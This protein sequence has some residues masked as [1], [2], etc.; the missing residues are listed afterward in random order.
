MLTR[1]CKSVGKRDSKRPCPAERRSAAASALVLAL[2]MSAPGCYL[3]DPSLDEGAIDEMSQE[4]SSSSHGGGFVIVS[5]DDADDGGHCQGTRCGGIY[6]KF[7]AQAVANSETGGTT[8]AIL[9]IGVNGSDARFSLDG[10]NQPANGGPGKPITYLTNATDIQNVDFS[11]FA[12]IYI[13]S[14]ERQT[15]GGITG[16]QITAL[17]SRQADITDFVNNQGGA[18][19][20]LTQANAPGGWGFLPVTLTTL[21]SDF[22]RAE[23]TPTLIDMA[24]GVT[25]GNLE[26]CCYHNVFTGPSGF[27]GLDVLAF[28][29]DTN[30]PSGFGLPVILGGG[31]LS[32]EICNDQRDNDGDGLIDKADPDCFICG[33][34]ILD[35]DEQCDDGNLVG[36]DGCNGVCQLENP[37]G[38]GAINPGE[39]CDDGNRNNGDGCDSSCQLENRAPDAVCED[40][41]ECNDP[42]VCVAAITLGA[43]STDPDGD[44]LSV[45]QSPAGPYAVGDH[46]VSVTVSDGS[47]QDSCSS[48]VEV[49]DCEPP[50]LTC[51]QNFQLQCTGNGSAQVTPPAATVADN[52]SA[53]V[54]APAPGSMPLGTS[55]LTYT[56]S[57]P[58]GNGASCVTAVTVV[59]TI[60]PDLSCPSNS[61]AECTG[62]GQ[63]V[64][65]PGLA[66]TSDICTDAT[67]NVPGTSS[68]PLGT[69]TVQY[70]ARDQSGNRASCTTNV[71]VQDTR[72][73]SI[74]CPAP[75]TAE[76]TGNRQ[77]VVDPGDAQATDVCTAVTVSDPGATSYPL[78]TSPVDYVAVDGSGNQSSCRTSITVQDTTPP[79]LSCSAPSVA[80]C[81]GNGQAVVDP[82]LA[83]ASDI[84]TDATVNVPGAASYPLGST[85]VTYTAMDGVGHQSSCTTSV[86]VADTIAPVISCPAPLVIE[87]TG[88][89]SAPVTPGQATASDSCTS[90]AITGPAPGTFPVGT[91]V[92]TYTATDLSGNQSSCQSTIEVR[93]TT[94]PVVSVTA[95]DPMWPPNHKYRNFDLADCGIVVEDE[96]GGVLPPS[97]SAPTITCVTSDEPENTRGDGNTADDIRIIDGDTVALRAERDGRSDGRVY[98][99]HFQVVDAAGNMATGVCPIGVPHDQRG[100]SAVDSGAAYSVCR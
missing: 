62:N 8:K 23:P 14:Y 79:A 63:A 90:A 100:T 72:D 41:S 75:S 27:S 34:N 4:L 26:H 50:N 81:T 25:P 87:C 40:V 57:D 92:V 56:A 84:C 60:P 43:S 69:T 73:P 19:V 15:G 13:P 38:N 24:P 3:D 45:T 99:I 82:G 46:V 12:V 37:C 22:E 58:A 70:T 64:V 53:T 67:V 9:A 39:E 16:A 54:D 17:N 76:C 74:T 68:Y 30:Y 49:L 6:P 29:R 35:P 65:D 71:I 78:G 83:Q 44:P 28:H 18:L 61:V 91:S 11:N 7:L 2:A 52:C 95:P 55:L 80:E 21:N 88:N 1:T 5:G 32:S 93:D 98:H 33:D 47:L 42:G 85:P 86:T 48:N 31:F 20:A 96:C 51:P 36:G 89:G 10:W 94:P 66:Q 97:V 59:D 77:A